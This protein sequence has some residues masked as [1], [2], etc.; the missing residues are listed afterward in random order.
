MTSMETIFQIN[1]MLGKFAIHKEDN[2]NYMITI[3]HGENDGI[4]F[5]LTK[6]QF[7]EMY[8]AINEEA[9]KII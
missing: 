9:L 2:G 1:Q 6:E 4:L 7:F 5:A 8:D 3:E